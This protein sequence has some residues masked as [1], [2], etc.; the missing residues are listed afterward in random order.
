MLLS[1]LSYS[2]ENIAATNRTQAI[3][4]STIYFSPGSKK[5]QT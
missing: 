5:I 1:A 4:M 2:D 3:K